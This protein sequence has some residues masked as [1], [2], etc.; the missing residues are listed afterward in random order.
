MNTQTVLVTGAT[1]GI[2][3]ETALALARQGYQLLITG[4]DATKGPTVADD[5]K[6]QTG[7]PNVTFARAD[8]AN[9]VDVQ[10]LAET[11]NQR[12]NRLDALINNAGFL[13]ADRE[14]TAEG[15]ETNFAVNTLTPTLLIQLLLPL[16]QQTPG[17]RVVNLLTGNHQMVNKS[18]LA[19]YQ[20]E[21]Q[22]RGMDAYGRTKLYNLMI[23]YQLAEQYPTVGFFAADPGPNDT[24]M[25]KKATGNPKGWPLAMRLIMPVLMPFFKRIVRNKPLAEGAKSTLYAATSPDLA[26]KTGLYISSAAKIVRSSKLSYDG[27]LQ[28]Q[29]YT[30]VTQLLQPYLSV[31]SV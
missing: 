27:A 22:Y 30:H 3:R 20:S 21:T 14:T 4:R 8:M 19:D 2:G 6:H 1:A 10:A 24:A 18:V 31:K 29:V 9:L 15:F 25:L 17:S 7:N 12:F 13:D 5:L 26:G 23:L 16:L 11:V 28:S